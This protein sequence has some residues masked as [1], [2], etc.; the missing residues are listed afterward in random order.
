MFWRTFVVV[1]VCVACFANSWYLFYQKGDMSQRG[2][3]DS[4]LI[5]TEPINKFFLD[6][7]QYRNYLMILCSGLLDFMT[8]SSCYYWARYSTTWRFL[9]AMGVFYS[10]RSMTTN[11]VIYEIPKGYNWG[12]PGVMSLFVPYGATADFFYSGHVGTCVLQYNEFHSN[13][14][15]NW[16]AF[17]IVTMLFQIF[18]M[19]ALRSH[20]TLDMLAAVIF[21]HYIYIMSERYSYLVDYYIFGIPLSKRLSNNSY[22]F[23]ELQQQDSSS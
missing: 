20:Y 5:A 2:I 15:S 10:L 1:G 16:A 23:S 17:C 9:L 21:A 8:L 22:H 7:I 11:L 19:V 3:K 14:K 4:L 12:Y 18:M 6:N 13:G